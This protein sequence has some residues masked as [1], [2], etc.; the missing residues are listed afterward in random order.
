[1]RRIALNIQLGSL[2]SLAALLFAP[3]AAVAQ[4]FYAYPDARVLPEN[5]MAIGGVIGVGDDELLRFEGYGRLGVAR[6]FDLGVELIIDTFD[7][8][9][10]SGAGV[11]VKF[12]PLAMNASIPFDLSLNSGIGFVSGDDLRVL[13]IPVGAIVSSPFRLE[14]GG[15]LIPY[16]GVY[17]LVVDSKLER[18]NAPD[19]TDTD[20]DVELRGG[21]R[22]AFNQKTSLYATLHLGRDVAFYLGF[23]FRL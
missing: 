3:C 13:Q 6:Y 11:D 1:M 17:L 21:L 19:L 8:R 18:P 7:E 16:L 14:S 12:S 20:L 22:Y 10:R 9:T 15:E 4:V 23:D 2:L 5:R